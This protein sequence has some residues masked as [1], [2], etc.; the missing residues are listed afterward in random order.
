MKQT[1][2]TLSPIRW[3]WNISEKAKLWP[4]FQTIIRIAQG[5]IA[6]LYAFFLGSVVDSAASGN[7]SL[8]TRQFVLFAVLTALSIVFL[9]LNRYLAER[10]KNALDKVFR[11]RVFS[12]L[13]HR[14]YSQ[15][16]RTHTGE[17]MTR[18]TS[19]TDIISKAV[20]QI[21]P[22]TVGA[23]V[24]VVGAMIALLQV[25]PQLTW[26]LLPGGLLM[27]TISYLFQ[28]RLKR[29]HK[30]VQT[31]DGKTRSF[32]QEQLHSLLVIHA[33]TQ[34]QFS[35]D[36]AGQ[37]IDELNAARMRRH[38]F[39]LF[40]NGA[41]GFAMITAQLLGIGFC[42]LGI[43]QGTMSYGTLSTVL[44]LVN[45]LETPL[46]TISGYVAQYY[47]M[48]A[49]AERLMDIEAY[50]L[51]LTE[52][53]LETDFIGP[54]YRHNLASFGLDTITFSY[55]DGEENVLDNFS[56]DIQ[57][58]EFIAF[59]G[60]SGC[61]KSTTLKMLL[62][63]YPVNQGQLYLKTTTGLQ[64][65]LTSAWRGLFAYVPQGNQLIS[66]TI[67][68]TLCFADPT[69]MKDETRIMHALKIA[70]AEGFVKELPNG[71][72]TLLGERG[73][74]LSEG[75]M[76]RLALARAILSDRPVLLLDEATSA[77]D[78]ETEEQL[79]KNLRSMTDRTVLII[80]HRE[81]VLK[82][83]DKHVSFSSLS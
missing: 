40:C 12:Q 73:A 68:E 44:Y 56:L 79:L 7:I 18:I 35:T 61:G 50:Q 10:S 5:C 81:A 47:G 32:M 63:L 46:R 80:T 1:G 39:T 52:V 54:F 77:L 13:L 30:D 23:L 17:W 20:S 51:D 60:E 14:S 78:T 72:D 11:L 31:T 66:G 62:A 3:V 37:Q 4:L 58:G 48:L 2:T 6:L 16:S 15:V 29:Y 36:M 49:S 67:R 28:K 65:P 34:E 71:L 19:D 55:N 9:L 74:G 57:K 75:Q 21:I 43:I 42:G 41:L 26:I 8:F 69:L 64:Q 53:P 25:V 24:R 83:C 22:E 70:C 27:A 59:T 76:Q 82:Y 38:R 33:F 45:M